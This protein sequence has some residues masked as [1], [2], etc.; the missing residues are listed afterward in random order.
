MLGRL[1]Q[2]MQ[3]LLL[4]SEVLAHAYQGWQQCICRHCEL[5]SCWAL[6]CNAEQC[7][8]MLDRDSGRQTR[9]N[10]VSTAA[11]HM[12][13]GWRCAPNALSTC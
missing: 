4:G 5:G 11:V 8:L 2:D 1:L 9:L 3:R 6:R 7:V 12:P 13:A 10:L